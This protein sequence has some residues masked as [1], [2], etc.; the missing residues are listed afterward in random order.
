MRHRAAVVLAA[1]A[2]MGVDV[3]CPR[4]RRPDPTPPAGPE[5]VVDWYRRRE[6]ERRE[7]KRTRRAR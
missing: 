4:V 7:R 1:L 5:S 6:R 2:A 3:E